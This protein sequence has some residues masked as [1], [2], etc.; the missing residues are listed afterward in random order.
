M[1]NPDG[2]RTWYLDIGDEPHGPYTVEQVRKALDTGKVSA[3]TRAYGPG[4][5]TWDPL[6]TIPLFMAAA[7]L[8]PP[9]PPRATFN[10]GMLA[11]EIDF[12]IA[13][14]DSQCVRIELDPGEAVVAEAGAMLYMDEG[15]EMET[16][17]GD[18]T[19]RAGVMDGL[20]G[21]GK[22][23]LTGESLFM[24]I[25][26]NRGSGKRH[27]A[28]AAPYPGKIVPMNLAEL[29]G[30]VIC[31]KDAFL[32]AAKGVSLG[33]AFQKKIGV[34]LFGG[35]GF[36]MQRLTGDGLSF[37]HAGGMLIS[38]QL[39]RGD[40]LNVDTGC[41]VALE[42]S[43]QFDIRYVGSIKSA[44]FGGEGFFYAALSGP[45]TVWLQ[46]MPFS[47]LAGRLRQADPLSGG[48]RVGEGS[49]LGDVGRLFQ[50]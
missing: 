5:T 8:A 36:I 35:E 12:Q 27:V 33:I 1:S 25:F 40:R 43:V 28:F 29:G 31:Q 21:A 9:P 26:T 7:G 47:R 18:G 39:E 48:R 2:D 11:H 32:C 16:V 49:V 19:P 3:D 13:G 4:M 10:R 46:T 23:L 24:T 38:R 45:G 15:V 22:R 44:V 37:V 41:L 42:P 20:V 17:F 50:R 30:E 34:A 14:D 6:N